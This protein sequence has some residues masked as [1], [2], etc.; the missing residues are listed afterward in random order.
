MKRNSKNPLSIILFGRAG[1]GKGTQ[2]DLLAKKFHLEHFSSG[3][4][5]RQRQKVGDFTGKKL[6]EVMNRGEWVPEST[7]IKVWMDKLESF[8]QKSN[9]KGWIYD[10]GPRLMLEA[11]LL[12]VALKWYEWDKN[13]KFILIDISKKVAFD[14]LT[15]RRQCKVCGE[16]IPWVGDFKKIE[17][18]HKCGGRLV[19]RPDDKSKAIRKRLEQFEKYTVPVINYYKKQGKVIKINGE[20]SIK[21][22]FRDVLRVLK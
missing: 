18:C 13:T 19:L 8:K 10:G 1:S 9:F 4:A 11:K 22:V 2:A 7:I 21:N 15:K 6:T 17:T 5:L 14:R 16:L 12:E 20:Q 3:E